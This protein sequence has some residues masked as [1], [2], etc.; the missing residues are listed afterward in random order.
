MSLIP[1]KLWFRKNSVVHGINL[2]SSMTD[3]G[4]TGV[5]PVRLSSG[6]V[7]FAQLGLVGDV[8]ASGLKVRKLGRVYDVIDYAVESNPVFSSD[9]DVTATLECQGPA[10][11]SSHINTTSFFSP[12]N[13][14]N[15]SLSVSIVAST[16]FSPTVYYYSIEKNLNY[17]GIGII[18]DGVM[19][20]P[21]PL[22]GIS[23]FTD[24]YNPING[25]TVVLQNLHLTLS[26]G[27]HNVELVAYSGNPSLSW[28]RHTSTINVTKTIISIT[29]L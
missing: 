25:Y 22:Y 10:V 20:N 17:V 1:E 27:Y 18:V 5:L 29:S 13:N 16:Y 2:Y 21:L 8:G 7:A 6:N 23:Y 3:M 14:Y 9:C 26:A 19:V 24:T 4:I 15:L 28:F 12:R 11:T